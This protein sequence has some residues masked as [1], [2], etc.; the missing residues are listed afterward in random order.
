MSG[1]VHLIVKEYW[2]MIFL[3]EVNLN[4][5][6]G[7]LRLLWFWEMK[8]V[9]EV[10][11]DVDVL[12]LTSHH[13]K[14]SWSIVTFKNLLCSHNIG[15]SQ[16]LH[17]ILGLLALN[18]ASNNELSPHL[19]TRDHHTVIYLLIAHYKF[20]C[21]K[22]W[23]FLCFS[24]LNPPYNITTLKDQ[25]ITNLFFHVSPQNIKHVGK[26]PCLLHHLSRLIKV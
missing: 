15:N 2:S 20:L 7:L 21:N 12:V 26:S 8:F 14:M 5:S 18:K 22:N 4:D 11:K 9:W 3:S 10:W 25:R 13:I 1:I 17:R 23:T 6:F 19:W 24:L 16:D